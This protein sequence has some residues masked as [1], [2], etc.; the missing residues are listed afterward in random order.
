MKQYICIYTLQLS[1]SE[2]RI[3][4]LVLLCK[5]NPSNVGI[6]LIYFNIVRSICA[7]RGRVKLI[8]YSVILRR[9]V[10][11]NELV[12]QFNAMMAPQRSEQPAVASSSTTEMIYSGP[13]A[14]MLDEPGTNTAVEVDAVAVAAAMRQRS[15][16]LAW[17]FMAEP[18]IHEAI[19]V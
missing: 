17:N 13:T 4:L 18:P 16:G 6:D 19:L 9:W 11:Q 15:L 1:Y 2:F 3:S 8:C 12:D 10:Y 14:M 5:A 7:L